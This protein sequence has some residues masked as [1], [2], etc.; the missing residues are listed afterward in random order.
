MSKSKLL[1]VL[2]ATS[3]VALT[4]CGS[5]DT[6]PVADTTPATAPAETDPMETPADTVAQAGTVVEVASANG[7]FA[8]LVAAVQAAGL[9]ETLSSEGPFTVFAPSD[10]AFAALPE[11]L[12][13]KLLLPENKDVLVQILTYHVLGQKVLAADVTAGAVATV[14]GSEL[15]I[16][17]EN[18]VKVNDATVVGTD[19]LA[20]NGVIHVIDKVLLPAGLDISAL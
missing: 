19:V 4:A 11:G 13:E 1:A 15:T 3:L 2:A 16:T 7:S 8:T 10:A 9:S 14:E 20:S 6:A 18:G 5:D 12:V 17:T